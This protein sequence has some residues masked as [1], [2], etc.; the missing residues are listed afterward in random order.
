MPVILDEVITDTEVVIGELDALMTL[1]KVN[2]K[3]IVYPGDS[4]YNPNERRSE[5]GFLF[6]GRETDNRAFVYHE[7]GFVV[8][9]KVN[10]QRLLSFMLADKKELIEIK[11]PCSGTKSGFYFKNDLP[12]IKLDK[13]SLIAH[14]L[15]EFLINNKRVI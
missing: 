15:F 6:W 10:Q 9:N 5:S 7:S 11:F 8:K 2:S 13:P 12:V 3:I 14:V 1:Y 4:V